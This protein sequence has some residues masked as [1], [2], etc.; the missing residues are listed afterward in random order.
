MR[1]T[2]V[3][4]SPKAIAHRIH[5]S[6]SEL[7]TLRRRGLFPDPDARIGQRYGWEPDRVDRFFE[8]DQGRMM[9]LA[10]SRRPS[11]PFVPNS[12]PAWWR[13]DAVRY[14]G[15]RELAD[16]AVLTSAA[17]WTHYYS[18]KLPEPDVMIGHVNRV[19]GWTPVHA[20]A[21]AESQG[22]QFD[23]ARLDD[24]SDLGDYL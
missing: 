14:L 15:L 24:T 21:L 16:A 13:V 1:H 20:R 9:N 17:V 23:L 3:L 11:V 6:V 7:R 22:W 12:T 10:R 4:L 19:A 2:T 5:L 18:G 8:D